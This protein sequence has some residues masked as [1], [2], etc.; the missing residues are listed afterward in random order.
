M[1]FVDRLAVPA[2]PDLVA[3]HEEE[4]AR[5][6]PFFATPPAQRRLAWPDMF[7]SRRVRDVTRASLDALFNGCCAFCERTGVSI[8]H[9]RPKRRAARGAGRIDEDGYWWLASDWNNLY[10]CCAECNMRKANWFP[11]E[12]PPAPP[13]ATGAALAAERPLLVDPCVEDPATHFTFHVDGSV[14]PLTLAGEMTIK[15]LELD[16]PHL[17]GARAL[18]ADWTLMA[19]ER[20]WT[21]LGAHASRDALA[22]AVLSHRSPGGTH[23]AVVR[24]AV[25]DFYARHAPSHTGAPEAIPAASATP[26]GAAP[27]RIADVDA[28]VWLRRI[29]IS[30]FKSA[31]HFDRAFPDVS[32]Q[33]EE[34]G[35]P[36]MMFLGE[37]GAGKTSIL[38]AVALALMTDTQRDA[39]GDADGWL[40]KG[41]DAGHVRL[42]F[43]NGDQRTLTFKKK[44]KMFGVAGAVPAMPVLAYGATRLLPNRGNPEAARL[45]APVSVRNLFEPTFPLI[46]ATRTLCDK[47]AISDERFRLL[48]E[49][50][51][52]LLPAHAN[53]PI[54]RNLTELTSRVN[55]LVISLHELSGGYRSVLALT[56]DI[57]LHLTNSSFDM[58]SA[59][60]LVLIDEL[61]L[62]L[63]PQWKIRVV[64]QLRTLFPRVRFISCTHDPLCVHGLREGELLVL[65]RQRVR[66]TLVVDQ[67]DIPAGTRADEILTGPWFGV[68]S[69]MDAGTLALMSEH[70]A[71]L[72]LEARTD[73]QEGSLQVLRRQLAGRLGSYG[74]KAAQRAAFDDCARAGDVEPGD[75]IDPA[76][77]SV[78]DEILRRDTD[79]G[80]DDAP[81]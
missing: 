60:G 4:M 12:G 63:H 36:W 8:E 76:I 77:R 71:L 38:Q 30:N 13:T 35:Q 66:G 64:E 23:T 27:E 25:E 31:T 11:I 32:G 22:F 69:T 16:N 21:A 19:C 40:S 1:I 3:F 81:V 44:Q 70:S 45:P 28:A 33:Q 20:I 9:F 43:T 49:D 59:R 14:T 68:P 56:L 79:D 29:E 53:A 37:N 55:K 2:P 24:A 54:E 80:E 57:M 48:A 58:E 65:S 5:L 17:V 39:Y 62:H 61:E 42:T 67:I 46:D 72:Q 51:R 34:W 50:L 6:M 52:R 18:A 78:F 26:A 10:L 74:D 73:V 75:G 7:R 15:I 47:G 41:A